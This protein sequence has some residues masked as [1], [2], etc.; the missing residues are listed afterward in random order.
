ME[1]GKLKVQASFPVKLADYGVEIPS[2][3]KNNIAEVVEVTVES[4]YEAFSR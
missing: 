3:V 2:V 1:D 4:T